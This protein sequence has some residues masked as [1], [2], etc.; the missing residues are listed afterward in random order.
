MLEALLLNSMKKG[1][2]YFPNSGPGSKTLVGGDEVAGFFGEVPVSELING[3][4]LAS[5]IGLAS[6]ISQF[7]NEPWLKFIIDGRIVYYAKKSY[8]HSLSWD[9]IK[10]AGGVGDKQIQVGDFLFSVTLPKGRNPDLAIPFAGGEDTASSH[11]SEWNRLM[12][13]VSASD[14]PSQSGP[15][16]AAYSDLD[17][18]INYNGGKNNG[19]WCQE[20]SIN[21]STRVQ[22]GSGGVSTISHHASS[23]T[24][25]FLCWRPVL[26]LM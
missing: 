14:P 23:N 12:Y 10:N 15:N 21:T 7:E 26:E 24:S 1:G 22:R 25:N 19:T 11:N 17:L 18:N 4:Q 2:T 5:S 8:R 13:K 3:T 9:N 16:W 6:G 20:S